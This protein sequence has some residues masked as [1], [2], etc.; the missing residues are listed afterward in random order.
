MAR[1]SKLKTSTSWDALLLNLKESGIVPGSI[2][3][4]LLYGPPRT[5]KSTHAERLFNAT[6]ATIFEN[7]P[8]DNIVGGYGPDGTGKIVWCDGPIA[9]AMR[10]GRGVVIDEIDHCTRAPEVR[11]SLYAVLDDPP[12]ITL[13]SGERLIA[14]PGYCVI[15]TTNKM[16]SVL[17]DAI[18]DRFDL[19]LHCDTISQ[20]MK[21]RL[22]NLAEA[23]Q[24]S[25]LD[26]AQW[27][28]PCSPNLLL[29][30]AKLRDSGM[31]ASQ[32]AATL[33]PGQDREQ[34]DLLTLLKGAE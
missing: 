31:D 34:V 21:Q 28:R 3:R 26:M 8:V 1:I 18:L 15:G 25:V 23:A 13:P 27:L 14:K 30:A 12:A 32:I 6:R 4:I 20:G 16:P 17:P 5:G 7:M 22:G 2:S 10:E 19:I 11:G 29:A 24:R 33:Y 9:T